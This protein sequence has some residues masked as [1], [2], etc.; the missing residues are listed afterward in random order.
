MEQQQKVLGEFSPIL[1]QLTHFDRDH[2]HNEKRVVADLQSGAMSNK[3]FVKVGN[4]ATRTLLTR[5]RLVY[6]P[7]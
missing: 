7:V 5:P 1:M 4:L 6:V 3:Y 2:T